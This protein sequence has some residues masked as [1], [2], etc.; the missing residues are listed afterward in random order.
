MTNEQNELTETELGNAAGGTK[1]PKRPVPEE[2][3]T[4]GDVIRRR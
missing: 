4:G 3:G 1:S 2:E